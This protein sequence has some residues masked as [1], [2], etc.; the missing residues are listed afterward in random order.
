MLENET[1]NEVTQVTDE[2]EEEELL[3]MLSGPHL[4]AECYLDAEEKMFV[5][6]RD[7]GDE[8]LIEKI[9]IESNDKKEALVI[10]FN[11]TIGKV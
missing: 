7:D 8:S 6:I 4:Y 10:A 11:A 1:D 5:D 3:F 9:P 2:M